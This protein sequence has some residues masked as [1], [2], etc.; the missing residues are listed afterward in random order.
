MARSQLWR[1][2]ARLPRSFRYGT[3]C[4]VQG[5]FPL[6]GIKPSSLMNC[7]LYARVSTDKQA[8]KELSIPAQLAAAREYVGRHGW[9]VVREFVEAGASARTADRPVLQQMLTAVQ[10]DNGIHVVVVH[11][12]DRLA[13]NVYDHAT[14]RAL[15]QQRGVRLASVVENVDDSVSGQLVENIMASIAQFYSANLS[16]EVKKGLRQKVL[17]GGWPHLPPCGYV[18]VKK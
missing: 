2:L 3:I 10:S 7:V 11:K 14:I 17:H 12:I 8:E 4:T 13:R 1:S 15:L 6:C 5:P 9:T 16:E 18:Q